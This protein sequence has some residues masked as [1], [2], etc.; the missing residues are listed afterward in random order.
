MNKLVI[1][2]N[3]IV[4]LIIFKKFR[5]TLTAVIPYI[6]WRVYRWILFLEAGYITGLQLHRNKLS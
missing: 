5:A 4:L 3:N 2:S 1:I 6:V